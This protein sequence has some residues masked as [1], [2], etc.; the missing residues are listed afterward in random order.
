MD[1]DMM[2]LGSYGDG[3]GSLIP[4]MDQAKAGL[5]AGAVGA[6]GIMVVSTVLGKIPQPE[7]GTF[8]DPMNWRRA[9]GALAILAGIMGGRALYDRSPNASIAFTASVVGLGLADL[10]STWI[11]AADDGSPMVRTSLAGG[12]LSGADLRALEQAV[13]SA[14]PAY[15]M[16]GTV[17]QSQMLRGLGA[18]VTSV[19][20]LGSQP[21]Y[22]GYLS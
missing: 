5:M 22:Q 8:A 10:A 3:L 2:G 21:A 15:G 18:P 1:Y 14:S 20:E 19:T 16:Q 4:T 6:G 7:S 12:H 17:A 13:T 11:P 9:K